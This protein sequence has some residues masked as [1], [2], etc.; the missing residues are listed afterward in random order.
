MC[1]V[2]FHRPPRRADGSERTGEENLGAARFRSPQQSEEGVDYQFRASRATLGGYFLRDA[3]GF[4][5]EFQRRGPDR[6]DSSF[7]GLGQPRRR[8]DDGYEAAGYGGATRR[9]TKVPTGLS[10]FDSKGTNFRRTEA[11]W[12]RVGRRIGEDAG[13]YHRRVTCSDELTLGDFW[14]RAQR[15]PDGGRAADWELDGRR[16]AEECPD[17]P[18]HDRRGTDAGLAEAQRREG[19]G[20]RICDLC[21]VQREIDGQRREVEL[22]NYLHHF[23]P[24]QGRPSSVNLD[25]VRDDFIPYFWASE[26]AAAIGLEQFFRINSP[27]HKYGL[28]WTMRIVLVQAHLYADLF[29]SIQAA[30]RAGL[31]SG[32][33]RARAI[34]IAMFTRRLLQ[35]A[36]RRRHQ[37]QEK[38]LLTSEDVNVRIDVHYGIPST[39][40]IVACDQIQRLLAI[41]TLDGRIKVI[42][43]DNIEGLLISPKLSPYKY[44][45]FLQNHGFL[46]SITIDNDIQVWDL[47]RRSIACS[48]QWESNVTAF[49]VISGSSFIYVGDEYGLISVLKYDL[50]SGQLLQSGYRLTPDSLAE[51]AGISFTNQ[52]PVVGLLPQPLLLIAYASGVI[53]LWDVVEAHVAVVR[54]D[55]ALQLKDTV[56]HPNDA[57]SNP[58]D[59]SPSHEFEEKEISALCWASTDGSSVAVGYVDGDILFW[60]TSK[61]SYIKN[62]EAGMPP[63]VVKLQLSSAEKRLPVVV[64]H[65]LDHSKSRNSRESQLLV[66]G[67]DEIG[68]E[69]VVTVL[70]LEWSPGMESVKCT[71]RVDL[72]LTGS[73]ADM[74]LIPSAGT[75]GNDTDASLFVLMNPGRIHI[76]DTGSLSLS[77]ETTSPVN[78]PA[79]IPTSDPSMTVAEIFDMYRS[80]EVVGSKISSTNSALMLP[81]NKKWPLNGGV[82]NRVSST[83]DGKA[84]I[85]YVAGYQDGSVRI[86]DAT[87]PVFSLLSVLTNEFNSEN[88]GASLT[89]LDLSPAT[90]RLTVGSVCGMVRIYNL[91][92]SG[93]TRLHLVSE[94]KT[95]V[96]N[97]AQVQ[98]P[99]CEAVFN[100]DKSG[101]RSLKFTDDGSKLIVGYECSRVVVIDVHLFSVA[102]MTESIH[103]SPVISIFC[104]AIV[105]EAAKHTNESAPKVPHYCTEECIF[106][107]TEGASIYVINSNNGS[108]ISSKPIQLKKSTAVSLY[109]IGRYFFLMVIYSLSLDYMPFSNCFYASESNPGGP[110]SDDKQPQLNDDTI[111]NELSQNEAQDSEKYETGDHTLDKNKDFRLHSLKELYVLLCC[112]DSLRIYPA[113]A[114]VRGENKP[115]C[116]VKLSKPC[117]WTTVFRKSENVY[118]LVVFY[119][120]GVIEIRSLPGLELVIEFPLMSYLRWNV[121]AN[122]ERMISSTENLLLTLANGFE[123]AFISLLEGEND[124]RIPESLP[125]LHDEV[126]AAAAIAAFSISDPKRKQGSSP[127]ILGGIVK[128]LRRR[129]SNKSIWPGSNSISDFS[130][131]EDIFM[132]N[133]LPEPSTTVDEHEDTELSIDDIDIDDSIPLTSSSSSHQV[134]NRDKDKINEREQLL[135]DGAEIKPRI[136]TKEEIIA[137][138][139]NVG[140]ASSAAGQAKDKLLERQE[141]LERISR[142]TED[143]KDGAEDFASL[144]NEL[145]KVMENRKW[146]HI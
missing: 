57:D 66:Y 80:I 20:G 13:D 138:Y 75:T 108:M 11:G 24:L 129:K 136:R 32:S 21:V 63:N 116:K 58:I 43:G 69:E 54:G 143:L 128:G 101:V 91:C 123:V 77:E 17:G 59:D 113:K 22:E 114:V 25:Q 93:E 5:H 122:M 76:Y 3:S 127:G 83:E 46:V 38:G 61:D 42:G 74:I 1:L 9:R 49:S 119:E 50:D 115:M 47:Q 4:N 39:A 34:T 118:G 28:I 7:T 16:A 89:A 45:E 81:G 121:K 95:E 23:G 124:L 132:R 53:I 2:D 73:F 111:R 140:D 137:K 145:V 84:Q 94:T 15:R 72:T 62:R 14:P 104:K 112:K 64:L 87:Y 18:G 92:S 141:K 48:L 139:R 35:K 41:G 55:K 67:G 44:L 90:L 133:P 33:V 146:Y 78:F 86:W 12:G 52:Q 19:R 37:F 51:A 99:R 36:V 98:G 26:V 85:L 131:L 117:C 110:D 109:V 68:C 100:L 6:E 27:I 10:F 56:I 130:H 97:S 30:C 65:W 102:F 144:A 70:N 125:S 29:N 31:Q 103:N 120:T 82:I 71:S 142:R 107:L 105:Y 79:C 40:S 96:H 134:G 135:D 126:L 106:L 60:N 88:S 8:W